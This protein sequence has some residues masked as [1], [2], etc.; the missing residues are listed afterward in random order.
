MGDRGGGTGGGPVRRRRVVFWVILALLAAAALLLM[1]EVGLGVTAGPA[2][3]ADYGERLRERSLAAQ[4]EVFGPGP[5][6]WDAFKR[7][8]EVF[9]R[10]DAPALEAYAKAIQQS[11]D[12]ASNPWAGRPINALSPDPDD[13]V[14]GGT[15]DHLDIAQ[16]EAR[17]YVRWL[18]SRGA[19]A[20]L[21]EFAGVWVAA[22]R[23]SPDAMLGGVTDSPRLANAALRSLLAR[24]LVA[25]AEGRRD[26]RLASLESALAIARLQLWQGTTIDQLTAHASMFLATH[27]LLESQLEHPM[28]AAALARADAALARQMRGLVRAGR[29]GITARRLSSA[30][31][32]QRVYTDD[33][34]GGGRFVPASFMA[35]RQVQTGR[36]D[37]GVPW[38][39]APAGDSVLSNL[40]WRLFVSRRQA[41]RWLDELERLALAS[42]AAQGEAI[43]RADLAL[44][45]H[46][47]TADWRNPAGEDVST[48]PLTMSFVL[49]EVRAR[50]AGTRVMLA[51]ERYRLG[52][53]GRPPA[54]LGE[55][56]ELLAPELRVDPVTGEPWDYRPRPLTED[57]KGRPLTPADAVWPYTLRSPALPG[58]DALRGADGVIER[59]L[60]GVLISEPVT[61]PVFEDRGDAPG[62]G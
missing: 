27:M 47:E 18:E 60:E 62:G 14:Y 9:D 24:A 30:E 51:I 21:E 11:A 16:R 28:D 17:A 57:G 31:L 59:V 26:D 19:Y 55:L 61:R 50:V 20:P 39:V 32:V 40:H 12:G 36:A 35:L 6:N 29:L 56:G 58:A 13:I 45:A 46:L 4:R 7:A 23:R 25:A 22:V 1:R 3:A 54:E 33:G 5:N 37:P 41:D 48:H 15:A 10:D 44:A 34:S 49:R 8:L 53:G 42:L 52:H 43:V 38:H 2:P